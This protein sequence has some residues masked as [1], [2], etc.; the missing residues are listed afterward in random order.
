MA[1]TVAELGGTEVPILSQLVAAYGLTVTGQQEVE[2][3][4][5]I[6]SGVCG[7][8]T[9]ELGETEIPLLQQIAAYYGID[10]TQ[11]DN[12]EVPLLT[13][14]VLNLP[15]STYTVSTVGE[16][17]V[18]CLQQWLL[19]VANSLL[20]APVL[21]AGTSSDETIA[22][23]WNDTGADSY[24]LYLG[25]VI[26]Q[27]GIL[28][29][30]ASV[31]GLTNFQDYNVTVRAVVDGVESLDSNT[32]TVYP[33]Y[34]PVT[35][36]YPG[37]T[38]LSLH[39]N[40]IVGTALWG[41]PDLPIG[42]FMGAAWNGSSY[43][44]LYVYGGSGYWED[45]LMGGDGTNNPVSGQVV[46]VNDPGPTFTIWN[47]K[48]V[49]LLL[50][51]LTSI[52]I[53]TSPGSASDIQV[54]DRLIHQ[55]TGAST[56]LDFEWPYSSAPENT[57]IAEVTRESS[58]PS[59]IT[60]SLTNPFR[61]DFVSAGTANLIMRTQ[62]AGYVESATTATGTGTVDT[63]TGFATGSLRKHILDSFTG[64]VDSKIPLT[65]LPIFSSQDHITPAYVRN[66]DCWGNDF[67][68]ALTSIS[69]WNSDGG[70]YRA[71]ILVSP[72]H[73]IF[74][75]HF[76]PS[77]GS[78]V[79]FVTAG[80]VVVDRILSNV[81]ILPAIDTY[82]PDIAIG[83]LSSDVPETIDFA[84]VLPSDWE[85]KL[86]SLAGYPVM[87]GNTDQEEH[88]HIRDVLLIPTATTPRTL[89]SFRQPVAEPFNGF[90]EDIVGGDSSN[91]AFMVINGRLVL[92]TCWTYGGS[93]YGTSIYAFKSSINSVMASLGGGYS[94]TDADLSGFNSY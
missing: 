92:L 93:G 48:P 55:E 21:S 89:V 52:A 82:Y 15:G 7:V 60:P 57:V 94:L 4:K 46:V 39:G 29:T 2:L 18:P 31:S 50:G 25:G 77:V 6:A 81:S 58:D 87:C 84:R 49:L 13:A 86:P 73:V 27:S 16:T 40:W 91:P 85:S 35:I 69:P 63:L 78:T 90:Y 76:M 26:E 44:E 75:T 66:S 47:G 14:I 83:V 45:A 74:A 24:N 34:G 10:T 71:G 68:S 70:I 1:I 72:R 59:V 28:V 32:V 5:Q 30:S 9:S 11:V 36:V 42:V 43:D 65:G 33:T 38:T 51:V 80:N 8:S 20:E 62:S 64:Y 17:E 41:S 19:T 53:A 3:L 61:W 56:A 88:L 37:E 23:N 12:T 54:E 22:V 79:R 67:V